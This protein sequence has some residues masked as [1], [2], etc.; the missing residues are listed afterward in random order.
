MILKKTRAELEA[1]IRRLRSEVRRLRAELKR[2]PKPRVRIRKL[3]RIT[4]R[5]LRRFLKQEKSNKALAR[6]YRVHEST[7]KQRIRK[8]GLTGIR[9]VGRKPFVR[10]P[11]F[12]EPVRGWIET[13]KYIDDLNGV[14]KFQNIQYPPFRYINPKTLVCSNQKANPKGKFT[15]LGAY[16]VV[17][18]S[19]VFFINYARV[20]YSDKP[21]DF[22]EIYAWAK[23][24]MLDILSE[25]FRRA[26]FV[27]ER[28]IALTFLLPERK[29][30][31]I[32][33]KRR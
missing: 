4:K 2:R 15:T 1:E 3:R 21:V 23:E 27:I 31:A 22:D 26:P 10:K 24:N 13:K 30:K 14:Y 25:Q 9:K 28:I 16:F 7:I 18:Q 33:A 17:E 20:R 32:K 29:P 11:K 12:P 5:E 6:Y 8:Y 19:A